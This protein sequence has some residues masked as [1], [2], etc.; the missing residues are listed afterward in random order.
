MDP[1]LLQA[2]FT[3]IIERYQSNISGY[4]LFTNLSDVTAAVDVCAANIALVAISASDESIM[5]ALGIPMHLNASGKDQDWAFQTF[6]KN[7]SRN[8]ISYQNPTKLNYLSDYSVFS[9]ALSIYET[10]IGPFTALVL[11]QQKKNTAMFGWG[12]SEDILVRMSSFF[13]I[14][15]HA[16]DLAEN[17]AFLSNMEV[18]FLHQKEEP[19]ATPSK[20]ITNCTLSYYLYIMVDTL[21]SAKCAHSYIP[22]D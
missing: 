20:V 4:V 15:V 10:T 22:Y 7:Y 16:S 1:S 6:F 14:F 18:P 13:G 3:D 17:L 2:S 19:A 9:N 5:A 12:P 11:A 21:F 8:V